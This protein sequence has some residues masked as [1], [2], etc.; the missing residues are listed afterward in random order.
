MHLSLSGD[1]NVARRILA[2]VIGIAVIW[3]SVFYL[4]TSLVAIANFA[5]RYPA[6]DQFRIYPGDLGLPFPQS[7]IQLENGHRPVLPT[8]VR[9]AEA[10]WFH[11]D[12]LLQ[13]AAGTL[14]AL[15]VLA[16]V[17]L[18]LLRER[19]MPMSRRLAATFLAVL[20]L[21][22]LGNAR[23]LMHGAES[24]HVYFTMLGTTL[25]VLSVDNARRSHPI[26]WLSFAGL[27]CAA[28]T[29]SFGTGMAS[30]GAAIAAA[31]IVRLPLRRTVLLGSI[32]AIVVLFYVV[33]L[34]GNTGVHNSLLF[35]PAQNVAALLR[36]LSAPWM[37]AWLG[38]ADPP[39]IPWLQQSA[40]Q[41]LTGKTL[42]WSARALATVWGGN[43]MANESLAVGAIGAIGYGV[44]L[45]HAWRNGPQLSR[46][47]LLAF[48]LA[49]FAVGAAAIVCI[50][51][52][53][54]FQVSPNQVFADRYLPWSCLFWLG[55]AL[56][57]WAGDSAAR[58]WRSLLPGIA[59]LV[60]ALMFLPSQRSLAGWS[61]TVSRMLDKSAVAAQLGIWDPTLF[62][63]GADASQVDVRATLDL[64]KAR[65]LSM[66]AEPGYALLQRG[67]RVSTPM[68]TALAGATARVDRTF[69]NTWTHRNVA[70]FEGSVPRSEVL[71]ADIV[72]EVVDQTGAVRGLA[73]F[74]FIDESSAPM[75]YDLPRKYGFDGYVLDPVNGE[76]LRILIVDAAK[77]TVLDEVDLSIPAA[78]SPGS[79]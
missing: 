61:A 68:R 30:F 44:V 48:G 20:A 10:R 29:F 75:R 62:P 6:F 3:A 38:L 1:R 23:M 70:A 59:A 58:P 72:L 40:G 49:T 26:L 57:V 11:A 69:E 73:A 46:A 63:D 77:N 74:S 15:M 2:W 34:P 76:S 42:N 35:D 5:F 7:A 67:S 13:V 55:L 27:S 39:L 31:L 36:W 32:L 54:S 45:V 64:M 22:W 60:L 50:A 65:G 43:W 53:Q 19:A 14:S 79:G 16:L 18:T 8:L 25:A 17:A 4:W 9:L 47:R 52:L 66:Y 51:R 21:F 33:L 24:M 56:Y 78:P 41:S 71:P 12:Q 28:A 37:N